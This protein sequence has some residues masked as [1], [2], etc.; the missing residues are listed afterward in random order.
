MVRMAAAS[1]AG[2]SAGLVV[3]VELAQQVLVNA[4]LLDQP[5]VHNLQALQSLGGAEQ[6]GAGSVRFRRGVGQGGAA[7]TSSAGHRL[8]GPFARQHALGGFARSAL[9]GVPPSSATAAEPGCQPS[10]RSMRSRVRTRGVFWVTR[11]RIFAKVSGSG[12]PRRTA[13][14]LVIRSCLQPGVDEVC[15]SGD[16]VGGHCHIPHPIAPDGLSRRAFCQHRFMSST[17]VRFV[18]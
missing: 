13:S 8:G 7:T 17:V 3:G 18:A 9:N 12:K 10:V 6:V 2:F 1:L 16:A 14:S 15:E 11:L 5:V 4:E